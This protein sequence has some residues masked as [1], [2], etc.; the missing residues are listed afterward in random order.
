MPKVVV[1]FH[2]C[3]RPLVTNN[4]IEK[5]MQLKWLTSVH[6]QG[7]ALSKKIISRMCTYS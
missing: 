7:V 5:I 4:T 6:I 2:N 1:T 3:T